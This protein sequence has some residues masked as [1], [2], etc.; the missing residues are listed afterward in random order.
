MS[1]VGEDDDELRLYAPG[2]LVE[3]I[4]ARAG[5]MQ[6]VLALPHLAAE[7]LPEEVGDIRLVVNGQDADAHPPS[8]SQDAGVVAAAP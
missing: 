1:D 3:R 8:P 4:F 6:H 7:V 5:E 2:E